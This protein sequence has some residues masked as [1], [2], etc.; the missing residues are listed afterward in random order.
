MNDIAVLEHFYGTDLYNEKGHHY[1]Y[2]ADYKT[3]FIIF[4]DS[5]VKYDI[6]ASEFEKEKSR[7]QAIIKG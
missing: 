2:D 4:K 1:V 7:L 3:Y 5:S 6:T